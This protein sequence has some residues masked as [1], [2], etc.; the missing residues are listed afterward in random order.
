MLTDLEQKVDRGAAAL[1][2]GGSCQ[3][4]A[5]VC[6]LWL[7]QTAHLL[8]NTLAGCLPLFETCVGAQ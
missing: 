5:G 4:Q 1:C 8:Q 2:L 3:K 7:I 6:P